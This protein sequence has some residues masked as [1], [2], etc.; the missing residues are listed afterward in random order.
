MNNKIKIAVLLGVMCTFLTAGI[1]VQIKT[2]NNST[3][4]VGKTLV[5]NELRDSVLRWKQRYEKSYQELN[6]KENQLDELRERVSSKD[7]KYG[8]L[9]QSLQEYN[10]LLGN[11][12]LIG[13]GLIITL[14]DG[15][16]S[17]IKGFAT[18]Y[19]VH[20]G[21]LLEVVNALKNAGAEAISINDQRIVTNTA[22]SCSGNV[23]TING[24]KVGAPF[25]INAIGST[26]QLYGA[27]TIP[28]GYI[29]ILEDAGVQVK[30]EQ[31]EK[32]NVV[33]PKYEGI[34]KFE[35]ATIDE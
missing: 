22:I 19:I 7:E 33:V 14:N 16:S 23:I 15:D 11:S 26:S 34:Y 24:E 30:I 17:I 13:K 4:T 29:E 3:T 32:E 5:E 28:G 2:V 25:V 21:D 20:D 1:V 10:L 35:Y 18:D 6:E 9:T 31:I 8:G 27:V 12:E